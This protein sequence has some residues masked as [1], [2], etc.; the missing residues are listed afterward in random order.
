MTSGSASPPLAREPAAPTSHSVGGRFGLAALG[1][2][3]LH[4]VLGFLVFE[5]TLFPGGDNA[6][7]LILGD[8]LRSGEGYRDLH[9]PGTPLHALYP[10]LL[11][12]LLAGLGWVGGVGLA[13]VVML[14]LTTTTVW[15]AAH[16]GRGW[17][18]AGPSLG[19]A[20]LLAVNPTLLEY[21]HYILSEA[22]FTLCIVAALWLSRRKDRRGAALAM[23]AAVAAFATRTAGMTILVA[24]PLAWLL[25]GRRRRALWTGGIA[26]GALGGWALYQ[27][28]A[29][30]EQP[31]YL[32]QL[33][34]VDPYTPTAGSVGFAGLF[35]RAA[36]NCWAYV[37]RVIPE[38]LLG[39]GGGAGVGG[40]VLGLAVAAA[41]LAGWTIR[42]RERL[43]APE[44]FAVLYAGLIAVWP[45]VWTD[46]RFLLPLMPVVLLLALVAVWRL[47][48]PSGRWLKWAAPAVIAIFGFDWVIRVAPD[49]LACASSFRNG[50]ACSLPEYESLYAAAR[51]AR[52]NTAPDAVIANRKPRLFFWHGRRRGD[53]YP[54]SDDPETVMRGLE[55]MGADYV[56]VGWLSLATDQYLI[57]AMRAH[58]DRFEAVYVGG[59]PP[60]AIFRLLP[61]AANAD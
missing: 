39:P 9:L 5:P 46:R 12:L 44:V 14:L 19:A 10:P 61:P 50:N 17:V 8:A 22:P 47:P 29:A 28:L 33:L 52:D 36:D 11:P 38:T 27:R 24:L 4:L 48:A 45:S 35:A 2:S 20:G 55:E 41:V 30:V 37:S 7:Y 54:F 60:S 49:R 25:E 6:G 3:I 23:M 13:K 53:L 1:F 15:A 58:E 43:R 40:I 32:T 16:F 42:S 18:G 21:G 31:G 56:L 34:L 26:A 59:E 51:W 57:P